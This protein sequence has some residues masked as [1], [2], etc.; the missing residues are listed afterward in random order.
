MKKVLLSCDPAGLVSLIP[1]GSK[2]RK[3]NTLLSSLFFLFMSRHE[4]CIFAAHKQKNLLHIAEGF[5]FL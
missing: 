4:N 2:F 5:A 3:Q 1:F